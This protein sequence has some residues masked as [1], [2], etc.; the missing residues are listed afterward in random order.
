[1]A[2]CDVEDLESSKKA[3]HQIT[4]KEEIKMA[5]VAMLNGKRL[6]VDKVRR[7]PLEDDGGG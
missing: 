7:V 2:L 4:E 6:V 3:S 1:V 5:L